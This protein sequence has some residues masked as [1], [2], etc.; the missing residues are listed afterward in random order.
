MTAASKGFWSDLTVTCQENLVTEEEMR[1][2]IEDAE[3]YRQDDLE[4]EKRATARNDLESFCSDTKSRIERVNHPLKEALLKMIERIIQWL[5]N[6][7]LA[8]IESM[9]RKKRHIERLLNTILSDSQISLV[10]EVPVNVHAVGREI[11]PNNIAQGPSGM[12]GRNEER[13]SSGGGRSKH[14]LY[15]VD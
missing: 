1:R 2:M 8:S 10:E 13:T 4:Q 11:H 14:C 5:E 6:G 15:N 12:V 3:R 7:P 9:D